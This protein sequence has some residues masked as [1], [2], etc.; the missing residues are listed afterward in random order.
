[1][2]VAVVPAYNLD[3]SIIELIDKLVLV[4]SHVI[5][6]DDK[7]PKNVGAFVEKHYKDSRVQVVFNP[8][9]LGVGGAVKNGYRTA[10]ELGADIVI[11]V[12]GDGQMDPSEI[13]NL[14]APIVANQAD[15]TKGNR[16]YTLKSLKVMPRK[17]LLGNSVLGIMNKFST[18]YWNIS[19]PNNGFTAISSDALVN[20]DLDKISNSYFF[21]SDML[22]RLYCNRAV[23][24]DIP[25]MSIYGDEKSSLSIT[26]AIFEF[27][28][29]HIRNACKRFFYSY[30]LRDASVATIELPLGISLLT[31]G[32]SF[33]FMSWLQSGS[34]GIPNSPG[35]VMLSGLT[36]LSGTQFVL[37]FIAH[38][39]SNVPKR[40]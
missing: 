14:V 8:R 9:N 28:F 39:V 34:T 3:E 4:V 25:M 26:R 19:D 40:S 24:R 36:I 37:A 2:L 21:E 5:L 1:M 18:G 7:C 15:Y 22:F 27:Y 30:I 11:K 16:F 6:V 38:D 35:T 31:F 17:R 23:V 33:S 12:D 32:I 13:P 20:L 10:L 29:K